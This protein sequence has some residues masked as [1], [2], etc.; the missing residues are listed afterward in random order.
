MQR[1]TKVRSTRYNKLEIQPYLRSNLTEDEKSMLTALRSKCLREIKTNF[2]KM[3]KVCQHCPLRCNPEDPQMDTQEHVLVCSKLGGSNVHVDFIHASVVE[4]S[5]VTKEFCKLM[6]RRST[7][8]EAAGT[9][10]DG[11]C[12][13]GAS[14][15]DQCTLG[16]AASFPSFTD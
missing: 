11:C 1:S 8:V 12:L 4:Q 6:M 15:L 5:Q 13:P 16:G 3:Y 2:P 10:T 7:Q 9:S 14:F